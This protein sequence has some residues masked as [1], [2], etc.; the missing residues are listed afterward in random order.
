MTVYVGRNA[1]MQCARIVQDGSRAP[2]EIDKN[3]AVDEP[4]KPHINPALTRSTMPHN[5]C[6]DGTQVRPMYAG[7][8]S[9]RLIRYYQSPNARRA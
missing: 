4:Q 6:K 9:R 3:R 8:P 1:L 2:H 7:P 5:R